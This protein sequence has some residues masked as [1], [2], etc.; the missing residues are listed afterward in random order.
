MNIREAV[1]SAL[2]DKQGEWL[3]GEEL[4]ELLNVSR[5][6]VWKHVKA[7]QAE[8]YEVESS[9]KKGYRLM[10]PPDLLSTDEVC[11]GLSTEVFGQ[12]DYFY[13]QEIDSTNKAARRLASDGYPEGTVV[14][15]EKQLEGRGRRG[16]S[17]YSPVRQGIYL[18]II[19]RPALPL[20]EISRISLLTAVALAET[21]ET[22]LNLPARIKWPNDILVNNRKI[23]G[24]LSEAVTDMD[25][26]E[27]IVVG[28]GINVNNPAEDFPD[29]FR[30]IPTSVFKE[31]LHTVSRINILQIL[32]ERMEYHYFKLLQGDFTFTLDKGRRLSL[33]I[34]QQVRLDTM[35]GFVE[36][37]AIDIDESGFLLVKDD[38]GGVQTIMSGEIDI[39]PA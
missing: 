7:L 26:I 25:G 32:L 39:L 37:L 5:T 34:G 38:K 20:K 15:A 24:I 17:W 3:S 6:T 9:S 8:G 4:S 28:M 1:L 27:Y 21:L 18:S 10:V 22:E 36:G 30:I 13:Y 2:K 33:V 29:D 19:L 35:N 11:P 12:G 23:A 16:R 14:V 31:N